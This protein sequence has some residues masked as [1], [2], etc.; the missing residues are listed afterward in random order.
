[1]RAQEI[2]EKLV[3]AGLP[4]RLLS[5]HLPN[6]HAIV[7]IIDL[8]NRLEVLAGIPG[9]A[10]FDG[11]FRNSIIFRTTLSRV[12]IPPQEW[13]QIKDNLTTYERW[14]IG[15][16]RYLQ[17]VLAQQKSDDVFIKLPP[18]ED[19]RAVIG[20]QSQI[21]TAL[22]QVILKAGGGLKVKAW[23]P[24]SLWL[25]LAVGG[26]TIVSLVGS[27]VWAAA[28]INKKVQEGRLFAEHVTA[29]K[30]K[31]ESVKDLVDAQARMLALMVEGEATNIAAQYFNGE[32][33]P[34]TIE[35][36]KFS[37]KEIGG[38]IEKGTEIHPALNA[39]ESVKNL[40]PNFK[41]LLSVESKTKQISPPE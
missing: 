23:E 17:E 32:A 10:E 31:N 2:Y 19:F 3:A 24:G 35:R 34:E 20:F 25:E 40:F 22:E 33:D 26:S 14:L 38:L 41:Q 39:P 18:G 28:V 4:G 15:L 12:E 5:N 13:G 9:F 8:R 37:I 30:L 16:Q 7:D 36:I 6:P 27:L 29:L 1:M 21:A 11:F